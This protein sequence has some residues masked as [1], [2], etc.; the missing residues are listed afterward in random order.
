GLGGGRDTERL[1]LPLG[2][3]RRVSPASRVVRALRRRV[4]G[5]LV[6]SRRL[7]P[8]NRGSERPSRALTDARSLT[9]RLRLQVRPSARW[10]R[11]LGPSS[12]HSARSST[13]CTASAFSR[14]RS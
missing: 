11:S 4:L 2:P 9:V 12:P 14:G 6:G 10:D 8:D 5:A 3:R 7:Y 13:R 1:R